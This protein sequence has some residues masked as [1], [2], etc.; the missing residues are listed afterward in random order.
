ML[1][2]KNLRGECQHCGGPIE[3]HAEHTGSMAA[4]P[5][6]GQQT[7]LLLPAPPEEESPVRKKAIIFTAIAVLILL[8]GLIGSAMA[9]KRAKRIQAERQKAVVAS[10]VVPASRPAG[11]F[12]TQGFEVSAALLESGP[13]SSVVYAVG[14]I[15]NTT[16]RQRFGVRVELELFSGSGEK[17]GRASDY[18]K[19]LEPG[20]NWKFRALVVDQRAQSARITKIS[21]MQ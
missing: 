11:P 21:E 10:E 15:T 12:A 8:G 5:H 13:G 7:E 19:V 17:L 1:K 2:I 9:L 20:A 3:F 14:Q 18:Q 16:S 4:C 6:C